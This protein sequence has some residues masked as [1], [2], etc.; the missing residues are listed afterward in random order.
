MVNGYREQMGLTDTQ[1][2]KVIQHFFFFF[3]RAACSL[4]LGALATYCYVGSIYKFVLQGFPVLGQSGKN[5]E[6]HF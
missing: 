1:I 2:L 5:L 3:A 4:V 6:G